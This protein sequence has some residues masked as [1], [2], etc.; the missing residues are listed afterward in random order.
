MDAP[1]SVE[2]IVPAR[3]A[4]LLLVSSHARPPSSQQS[5]QNPTAYLTDSIVALLSSTTFLPLLS[6]SMPPN[7]QRNGY[8]KVGGSPKLWPS[9][10]PI[11][12]PLALSFLPA[13][14]YSSQVSGNLL[15]PTASNQDLRYEFSA[16][17]MHQ[18]TPNHFFPSLATTVDSL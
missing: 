15:K 17:T 16:P 1:L 14:R 11:G 3:K 9:V 2:E 6:T 10:W 7:D 8:Q 12:W 13:A 4:R 18:G 5:F